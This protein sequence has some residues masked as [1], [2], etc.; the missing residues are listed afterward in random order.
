M[1]RIHLLLSPV[2][3]TRLQLSA[4]QSPIKHRRFA[5]DTGL[6]DGPSSLG[7]CELCS[8]VHRVPH[9]LGYVFIEDQIAG[10]RPTR[11]DRNIED[12]FAQPD[13]SSPLVLKQAERTVTARN[14]LGATA[15]RRGQHAQSYLDPKSS[16]SFTIQRLLLSPSSQCQVTGPAGKKVFAMK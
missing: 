6:R 9:D 16:H 8:C 14:C 1:R 15:L 7:E 13:L 10:A 11:A 12:Q 4:A 5:R 3:Q 2:Y